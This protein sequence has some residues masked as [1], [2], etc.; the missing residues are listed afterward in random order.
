MTRTPRVMH[1]KKLYAENFRNLQI[2]EIEFSEGANL[3]IGMN[4]Q[5]KSN[6]LEAVYFLGNLKSFRDAR[7]ANLTRWGSDRFGLRGEFVSQTTGRGFSLGVICERG[8]AQY[9]INE[10]TAESVEDFLSQVRVMAFHPDSLS[11]LKGGP[12]RRRMFIDRGIFS[13]RREH[14]RTLKEYNRVLAERRWILKNRKKSIL[15]VWTEKLIELG[16]KTAMMRRDYCH[17][18]NETV[19]EMEQSPGEEEPPQIEYLSSIPGL[20]DGGPGSTEETHRQA[21]SRRLEEAVEEEQRRGQTLTGPHRDDFLISAGGRDLS[22][23]GSQGQQ[24]AALLSMILAQSDLAGQGEAGMPILLFDD[25][26]SELD[27]SRVEWVCHILASR[28][29]QVFVSALETVPI[30]TMSGLV[31]TL[32]VRRG[33]TKVIEAAASSA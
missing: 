4:G 18:L 7:R 8:R 17:R 6:L 10:N 24:K 1:L 14:L 26:A 19:L 11:V 3:I 22:K 25:V 2:N 28:G 31:R 23:F 13:Q 30:R 16:V 27:A 21:F 20:D 32:L 12:G 33:E 5:G 29:N 9:N 15:G